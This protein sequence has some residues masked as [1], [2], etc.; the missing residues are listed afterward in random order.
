[1]RKT[2]NQLQKKAF[3]P[4]ISRWSPEKPDPDPVSG[5]ARCRKG[6]NEINGQ[7]ARGALPAADRRPRR[8]QARQPSSPWGVRKG[9]RHPGFGS[10]AERVESL[11]PP[12]P[13]GSPTLC[14]P[15]ASPMADA[16][17]PPPFGTP[18]PPP[19]FQSQV[20]EGPKKP[21]DN[22]FQGDKIKRTQLRFSLQIFHFLQF[23]KCDFFEPTFC[24]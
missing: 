6:M 21:H 4:I 17:H 13:L 20:Q 7:R 8:A 5:A 24:Q 11:S 12:S 16:T 14:G 22:S 9:L 23:Y 1:M 3:S 15:R 10:N 18:T 2:G 19:L